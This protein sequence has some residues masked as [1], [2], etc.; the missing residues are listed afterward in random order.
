MPSILLGGQLSGPEWTSTCLSSGAST[1]HKS[2]W[3]WRSRVGHTAGRQG[4]WGEPFSDRF[5]FLPRRQAT[6]LLVP[7]KTCLYSANSCSVS[8]LLNTLLN[9][10]LLHLGCSWELGR[11][12]CLMR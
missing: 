4:H 6:S 5:L 11:S 2:L 12:S 9:F 8:R 10:K 1:T 3:L 7:G